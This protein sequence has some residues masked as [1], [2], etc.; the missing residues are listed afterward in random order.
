MC[1]NLSRPIDRLQSCGGS[2]DHGFLCQKLFGIH[3]NP[4]VLAEPYAGFRVTRVGRRGQAGT[5]NI[6]GNC[7]RY[8]NSMQD[9]TGMLCHVQ[10]QTKKRNTI[11]KEIS[12]KKS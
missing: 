6:R 4:K 3:D 11:K 9:N 5:G 8:L 1:I 10:N 7:R 2:D 12:L